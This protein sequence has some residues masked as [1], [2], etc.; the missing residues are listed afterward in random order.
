M[1][2]S[3][4]GEILAQ[5]QTVL[6]DALGVDVEEVKPESKLLADLSADSIDLLDVTFRLE[7][8]FGCKIERKDLFPDDGVGGRVFEDPTVAQIV[9][10]MAQHGSKKEAA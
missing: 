1:P 2:A 7:R 8:K 10:Y 6:A 5:V 4:H 9:E 3:E